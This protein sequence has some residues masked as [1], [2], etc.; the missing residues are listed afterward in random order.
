MVELSGIQTFEL[1]GKLIRIEQN[2]NLGLRLEQ[3]DPKVTLV[4]DRITA[5]QIGE[6]RIQQIP[7]AKV[8]LVVRYDTEGTEQVIESDQQL[9]SHPE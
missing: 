1:S 6:I 7:E 2:G 5:E 3:S 9:T 8:F 4:L